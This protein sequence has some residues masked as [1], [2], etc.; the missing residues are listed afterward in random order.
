LYQ[1][2]QAIFVAYGPS[3][4]SNYV[5]QPFENIQLYNLMCALV[6]VTPAANNGTWGAL[7]HLLTNPPVT[8]VKENVGEMPQILHIDDDYDLVAYDS[9]QDMCNNLNDYVQTDAPTQKYANE[10]SYDSFNNF[11]MTKEVENQLLNTHAPSGVPMLSPTEQSRMI[12]N[13]SNYGLLVNKDYLTGYNIEEGIPLWTAYTINKFANVPGTNNNSWR[14]DPRLRI[15]GCNHLTDFTESDSTYIHIF[16]KEF[17]RCEEEAWLD[18]NLIQLPSKASQLIQTM[19]ELVKETASRFDSI[20]VITGLT[21]HHSA[22]VFYVISTC[23]ATDEN[24]W[25][26]TTCPIKQRRLQAFLL[27]VEMRFNQNCMDNYEFIAFHVASLSDIERVTKFNFFPDLPYDDK[28]DLL[29]RTILSS[30]L[31]IDP[32]RYSTSNV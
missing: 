22:A 2:M 14:S 21:H 13:T 24:Q 10:K 29:T 31:V 20:N 9:R 23:V 3:F 7:H 27:P 19:N 18:T 11:N 25:D 6:N 28:L 5:S 4:K 26:L 32:C 17:A 8:D 1:D 30:E 16:P 12:K 15:G